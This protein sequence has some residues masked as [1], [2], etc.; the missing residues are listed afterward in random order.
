MLL[1]VVIPA[2][3]ITLI[4]WRVYYLAAGFTG[5]VIKP[6][7]P[8]C[9]VWLEHLKIMVREHNGWKDFYQVYWE[10]IA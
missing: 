1:C 7:T 8:G 3:T 5:A 9:I 2:V 6:P 4:S 10:I